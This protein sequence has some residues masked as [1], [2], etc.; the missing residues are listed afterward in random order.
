[1]EK[2]KVKKILN[3]NVVIGDHNGDELVL[4]GKG[5]GFNAEKDKYV[6]SHKVENIY[7]KKMS[8]DNNYKKILQNINSEIIG[9][10]EE[11]IN[12][13]EE[14]L[15]TTLSSGIHVSL[16][17]HINFAIIRYKQGVIIENPFIN[18]IEVIYPKEYAL[19]LSSLKMINENCHI[20][21]P[22]D[23]AG[24]ICLHIRAAL[25]EKNVSESLA[26]T[27]KLGEIMS[28]I[29]KLLKKEFSKTSIEYIRTLTHLNFMI[30]RVLTGRTIK[31]PLLDSI[32]KEL[33]NEYNLGII[34]S[35]KIEDIYSVK[36]S[37]D[38][39][40]YLALHL[41]RLSEL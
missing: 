35:M 8:T 17:D 36:V 39:I 27:R 5:I 34:I 29:L 12:L 7:I 3:N 21:L 25:T 41:K 26:Y 30:E 2:Y 31:N 9:I 38:E 22:V 11:I 24:F 13:C 37:E 33:Y 19:A 6:S 18:E 4:I 1:M 23:E 32:K 10:S 28:L 40:G 14:T 16:P 15:N 20:K